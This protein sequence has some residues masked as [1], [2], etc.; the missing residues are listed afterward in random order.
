MSKT[1]EYN[2]KVNDGRTAD[3]PSDYRMCTRC[4]MDSM[5]P[6]IKF[7]QNGVCSFCKLQDR[8]S[9]TFPNDERGEKHLSAYIE[10][11]KRQGKKGA[12]DCILTSTSILSVVDE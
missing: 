5:V 2:S 12:Y 3:P 10:K 8:M 7:D 4:I 1:M 11:V 6:R 9:E